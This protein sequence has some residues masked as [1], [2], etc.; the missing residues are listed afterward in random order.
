MLQYHDLRM[1]HQPNAI[2]SRKDGI[3]HL[4]ALSALRA[5][6]PR[7]WDHNAGPFVFTLN[8]LSQSNVLVDEDWKLTGIIDLE[9]AA[10]RPIHMVRVPSW[11]SGRAV[12][13]LGDA[14]L[15]EYK[16]LYHHFVGAVAEEEEAKA[17][18]QRPITTTPLLSE[19]MRENWKTGRV[20]YT[21]ALD[22][23]NKF[24]AIFEQHLRPRFFQNFEAKVEGMALAR[25]WGEEDVVG[26]IE[27]K[28]EDTERYRSRAR[29][30]YERVGRG[31]ERW[32]IDG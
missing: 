9:F 22:S 31:A 32:W 16:D 8:D 12:D 14:N 1:R 19:I 20:W 3:S 15:E 6:L 17:R 5:L 27:E 4:S 10:V 2:L 26:F 21:M 30:I 18:Q 11:L 13:E 29:E 7:F 24:P 25:L 23:L 28:V